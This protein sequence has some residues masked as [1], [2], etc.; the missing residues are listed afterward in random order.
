MGPTWVLSIP[1]GPHVGPIIQTVVD[2]PN[3]V[4]RDWFWCC[5]FTWYDCHE[6]YH[7]YQPQYKPTIVHWQQRF[8][9]HRFDALHIHLAIHW[10]VIGCLLWVQSVRFVLLLFSK[11]CMWYSNTLVRFTTLL[12]CISI[13]YV[14]VTI[15]QFIPGNL[16]IRSAFFLSLHKSILLIYFKSTSVAQGQP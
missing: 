13:D 10:R 9:C 5:I 8:Y 7:L 14:W 15:I 1:D 4:C 12:D 11:S 2:P 3:D 16:C 6:L